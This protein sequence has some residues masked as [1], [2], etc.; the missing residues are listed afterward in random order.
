MRKLLLFLSLALALPAAAEGRW[1]VTVMDG[2]YVWNPMPRPNDAV[3]WTG[4]CVDG[5]T[6]GEGT[7]VWRFSEQGV[8]GEGR[9]VGFMRAGL[10]D[11]Q[12]SLALPDGTRYQGQWRAG[13]KHGQGTQLYA[14]GDRYEGAWVDGRMH[15]QGVLRYATGDVYEGAF[16]DNRLHGGGVYVYADGDRYEGSF[17]EGRAEGAGVYRYAS[18]GRYEGEFKNAAFDG[19]GVLYLE[20]AEVHGQWR[21][22][23]LVGRG[24]CHFRLTNEW[25]PCVEDG[26]KIKP[27]S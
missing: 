10:A 24:R 9:Y 3:T 22:G 19:E 8:A 12:G 11:G 16:E 13:L 27:A 18:G 6:A 14:S 4:A 26:G 7:L 17:R 21:E 20:D 23:N 2:C 25:R 15:G 5:K 1:Q